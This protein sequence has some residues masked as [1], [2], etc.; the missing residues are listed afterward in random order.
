MVIRYINDT[1]G[2]GLFANRTFK[3]GQLVGEYTGEVTVSYFYKKPPPGD[4][5]LGK[6]GFLY[7]VF[8]DASKMG[9]QTRFINHSYTP[10]LRQ[11]SDSK[12]IFFYATKKIFKR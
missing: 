11:K 6:R 10:N 1:I 8:I 5:V 7:N 9:N 2:Y 3:E 4:Y 12:R